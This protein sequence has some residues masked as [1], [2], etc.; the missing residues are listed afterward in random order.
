MSQSEPV[1]YT[2]GA[3]QRWLKREKLRQDQQQVAKERE[4][5]YRIISENSAAAANR[6]IQQEAQDKLAAEFE[7]QW[8]RDNPKPGAP[9][10]RSIFDTRFR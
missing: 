7:A 5:R 4:E 6:A 10:S 9:E 3:R 1:F 8:R 2:E